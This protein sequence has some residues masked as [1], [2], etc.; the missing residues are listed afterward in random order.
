MEGLLDS[1]DSLNGNAS[2][3]GSNDNDGES[4]EDGE[5]VAL[6][7]ESNNDSVNN[8]EFVG[9]DG[10]RLDIGIGNVSAAIEG[11]VNDDIDDTDGEK[12]EDGGKVSF[13]FESNN[14]EAGDGVSVI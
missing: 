10:L 6:F 8:S 1:S 2:Q 5:N 4:C 12:C 7:F 14:V 11:E 3:G 9:D 13:P